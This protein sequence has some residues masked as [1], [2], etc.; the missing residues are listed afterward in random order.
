MLLEGKIAIITGAASERGI[1]RAT[2]KRFADEGAKVVIVDLDAIATE[3]AAAGIGPA[4]RG[5]ACD[6]ADPD[7]C[8]ALIAA[9]LAEY[10]RI[11]VV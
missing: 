1:G 6:V 10:G 8:H 3:A 9:V 2:A 4:H 11:D 7:Q 5:F